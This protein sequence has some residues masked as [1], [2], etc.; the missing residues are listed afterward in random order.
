MGQLNRLPPAIV[1]DDAPSA[2][3]SACSGNRP[4]KILELFTGY[5]HQ[6]TKK[7]RKHEA[8]FSFLLFNHV[9]NCVDLT[10][11]YGFILKFP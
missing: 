10:A 4:Y 1:G 8:S 11:D 5:L 6:S 3:H 9:V 7:R 2:R